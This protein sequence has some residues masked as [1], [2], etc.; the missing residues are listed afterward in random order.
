MG[1]PASI[2]LVRR[3]EWADTDRSGHWHHTTAFRLTEAAESALLEQLGLLDVLYDETGFTVPRVHLEADFHRPVHYRDTVVTELA[4][5]EV[6][7]TSARF[8]VRIGVN[9]AVCAEVGAVI[10]LRDG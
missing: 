4:V 5:A 3:L 9:G 6:G 8:A 7:R 1:E 10:V 2:R